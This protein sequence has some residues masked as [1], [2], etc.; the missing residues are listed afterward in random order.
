MLTEMKNKLRHSAMNLHTVS[1]AEKRQVMSH[2]GNC[3]VGV[4]FNKNE[5]VLEVIYL[6]CTWVK[7]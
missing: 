5:E 6:M 3:S 7:I 2:R 4:E 1:L